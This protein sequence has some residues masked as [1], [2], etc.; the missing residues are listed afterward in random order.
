VDRITVFRDGR[1]DDPKRSEWATPDGFQLI[2]NA[3]RVLLRRRMVSRDNLVTSGSV[4]AVSESIHCLVSPG[5]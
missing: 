1:V 4:W 2:E 5:G 3:D